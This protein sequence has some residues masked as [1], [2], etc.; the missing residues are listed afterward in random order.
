MGGWVRPPAAGLPAW[1]PDK[2]WNV[3]LRA[4]DL[5]RLRRAGPL[6]VLLARQADAHAAEHDMPALGRAWPGLPDDL[7][8]FQYDPVAC[9]VAAGWS[10][11]TLEELRL[12]PVTD[13]SVLRFEEHPTGRPTRVVTDIDAEAFREVWL[14]SVEATQPR[15]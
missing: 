12:T 15:A 3:H 9:A 4:T 14:A 8:N 6:G 10:G 13:E 7:L 1:G 5:P 2:D 11:A